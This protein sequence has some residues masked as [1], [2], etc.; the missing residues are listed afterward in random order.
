MNWRPV[1]AMLGSTLLCLGFVEVG[2]RLFWSNPYIGESD[3]VVLV[4]HHFAG[5]NRVYERAAIDPDASQVELAT[6][7]RGYL[8]PS[9]RTP[10]AVGSVV[11]LGGS[12]TECTA[13]KAE[14]RFP[15]LVETLLRARGLPVDTLNAGV[16]GTN[17]H[18]S[19]NSLLNHIVDDK[20][21][22]AVLMHAAND[23]GTLA[24]EGSYGSAMA[25]RFGRLHLLRYAKQLASRNSSIVGFVRHRIASYDFAPMPLTADIAE[26][27][28]P[29][30]AAR[31]PIQPFADRLRAFV[32]IARGFG[33]VPVLMTQP[34]TTQRT[35]LTPAWADSGAQARFNQT[36]REV[37]T[38]LDV[39]LIDLD[40]Y[41]VN[42]VPGWDEPMKYFYDGM[43]VTDA[44]SR[45]YAEVI[46]TQLRPWIEEH[47]ATRAPDKVRTR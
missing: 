40:R 39:H 35:A 11:F 19:L 27:E 25:T 30:A 33:I 26:R 23:A 32:G 12:T 10:D 5:K 41:M 37:A 4:R 17:A 24:T 47:T 36:T 14:L 34:L 22:L 1:A 18:D 21:D 38:E 8:L 31:I 3:R 43:H 9:A 46:A 13:V 42:E 44:G 6:D 28:T 7:D 2:L 16:S 45:L 15:P 20:P 29:E